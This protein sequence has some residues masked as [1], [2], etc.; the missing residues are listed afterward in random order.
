[1]NAGVRCCRDSRDPSGRGLTLDGRRQW[2]VSSFRDKLVGVK[3]NYLNLP[4][5]RLAW[6]KEVVLG[7]QSRTAALFAQLLPGIVVSGMLRR[8]SLGEDGMSCLDR[9]RF[10]WFS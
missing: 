4:L 7:G 3:E 9:F 8:G 6:S 5:E 2:V 10:G 1:M